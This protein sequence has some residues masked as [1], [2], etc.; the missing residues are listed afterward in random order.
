MTHFIP[1][2]RFQLLRPSVKAREERK[3]KKARETEK[4]AACTRT[5]EGVWVCG[6]GRMP[7]HSPSC[8]VEVSSTACTVSRPQLCERSREVS[9]PLVGEVGGWG[10]DV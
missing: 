1:A 7:Y 6:W 4:S 3:E 5:V 9:W 2:S 8:G 10:A